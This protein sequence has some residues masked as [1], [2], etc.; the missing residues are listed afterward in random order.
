MFER[1]LFFTIAVSVC[2]GDIKNNQL[3]LPQSQQ[4][5]R[6]HDGSIIKIRQDDF[7][8]RHSAHIQRLI[9]AC[10]DDAD[11]SLAPIF[12][13]HEHF[14]AFIKR[15]K[16][17]SYEGESV[18][19]VRDFFKCVD[20]L[21]IPQQLVMPYIDSCLAAQPR[22]LYSLYKDR[23]AQRNGSELLL[24][25]ALLAEVP[26]VFDSRVLGDESIAAAI[27]LD[28]DAV[29]AATY[30]HHATLWQRSD[31]EQWHPKDILCCPNT[32][33]QLG[34]QANSITS[35]AVIDKGV[36]LTGSA[37]QTAL[38]WQKDASGTWLVKQRL[39]MIANQDA[40]C[41]HIDMLSCVAVID[42]QTLI[43]GSH[44]RTALI[45]SLDSQGAWQIQQQLGLPY[46]TDPARGHT[47]MLTSIACIGD[48]TIITASIDGTVY[49]WIRN[50]DHQWQLHQRLGLSENVDIDRGHI[51]GIC[52]LA[53]VDDTSFM[54]GSDDRTIIV[55]HKN[56]ED[57]WYIKQRLGC[58]KNKDSDLGHT[59]SVTALTVVDPATVLSGSID[60]TAI[61]WR[62][63]VHG[64]WQLKNRLGLVGNTDSTEFSHTGWISGIGVL[65]K[66]TVMTVSSDGVALVWRR[67][68]DGYFESL[69]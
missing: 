24:V 4:N 62:K 32:P 22:M 26:Y 37:D 12:E 35:L 40:R 59:S 49:V 19:E 39:G 67:D 57:I 18:D 60:C 41:G 54:T 3:F 50:L 1:C 28:R 63:D 52:S 11:V 17:S 25:D 29:I 48:H 7:L 61:Q 65:D 9:N 58:V 43:T 36:M 27:V 20:Y 33:D 2:A 34:G 47:G 16:G 51:G 21:D 8:V 46:N 55:W 66:L 45:W 31:D 42:R 10:S 30:D 64:V 56:D 44:D 5:L 69:S 14:S 13:T 53:V 68:I 15:L 23:C 6:V 38:V